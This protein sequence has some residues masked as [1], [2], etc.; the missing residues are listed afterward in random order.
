MV[1]V[2]KYTLPYVNRL[3]LFIFCSAHTKYK[4]MAFTMPLKG[5]LFTVAFTT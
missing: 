1:P 3:E 2:N 5:S 4:F